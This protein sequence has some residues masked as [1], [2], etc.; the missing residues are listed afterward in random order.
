M[1][2]IGCV[3]TKGLVLAPQVGLEP[4][5]LRL[6][7]EGIVAASRCKHKTYTRKNRILPEFGG[8]LRFSFRCQFPTTR[9]S[10]P[11]PSFC[12]GHSAEGRLTIGR[13]SRPRCGITPWG[14]IP[15]DQKVAQLP[16]EGIA[17]PPD[18][19]GRRAECHRDGA[20]LLL[21][22][23]ALDANYESVK[24]QIFGGATGLIVWLRIREVP[25]PEPPSRCRP[26]VRG[27]TCWPLRLN[28][29]PQDFRP[30]W[31]FSSGILLGGNKHLETLERS[32]GFESRL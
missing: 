15:G 16:G 3:E 23:P 6:T 14:R 2:S 9:L 13:T 11:I 32:D 8:T 20:A 21:A 28:G 26:R 4:T 12:P 18:H 31:T 27:V 19:Q 7:A 24:R 5:T 25:K 30:V 1:L 22:S 17:G 29:R 10:S